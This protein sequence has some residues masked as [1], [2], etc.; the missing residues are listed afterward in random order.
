MGKVNKIISDEWSAKLPEYF[1]MDSDPRWFS[2]EIASN[3]LLKP[4]PKDFLHGVTVEVDHFGVSQIE[5]KNEKNSY[6]E[7]DISSWVGI[8][9][10]AVHCYGELKFH[11][12]DIGRVGEPNSSLG[13]YLGAPD[14]ELPI[15]FKATDLRIKIVRPITQKD[16]DYREGDRYSGYRIGEYTRDW[17]EADDLIKEGKR[18]AKKYF[19]DYK[20]EINCNL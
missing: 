7:F 10:G 14:D 18:I 13:G 2:K 3:E 6:V 9:V 11:G 15:A 12:I 17:W 8:S 16:I 19:P 5:I 1:E 4:I 20:L